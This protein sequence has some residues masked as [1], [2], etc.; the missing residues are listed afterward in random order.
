MS[1]IYDLAGGIFAPFTTIFKTIVFE[2]ADQFGYDIS[3]M[4]ALPYD[5][6]LAPMKLQERDNYFSHVRQEIEVSHDPVI[7]H[8]RSRVEVGQLCDA[9]FES[10]CCL[11][12]RRIVPHRAE[13]GGFRE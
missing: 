11:P 7:A 4:A 5:W 8:A 6:R 9:P 10:A 12:G 3:S 1:A 2:M 13:R